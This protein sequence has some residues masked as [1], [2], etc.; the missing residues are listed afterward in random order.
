MFVYPDD[1]KY[2]DSH[3]Y[4]RLEGNV[5]TIGIT[6]FAIDQLGDVVF[7]ELPEVGET[8]SKG[9]PFGS[10]ESVK[11]VG[12]VY[13]PITGKVLAVNHDLADSPETIGN[14]PYGDSWMIKV[15][16]E[17]LSELDSALSAADYSSKVEGQ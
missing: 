7:I 10:V 1:L 12:D 9:L 6:A 11:A 17:D 5:A 4:I 2:T 16:V 8:I 13:A 15:E 14:D 3:E